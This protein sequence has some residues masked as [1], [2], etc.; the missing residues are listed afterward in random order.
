MKAIILIILTVIIIG[1]IIFRFFQKKAELPGQVSVFD[2]SAIN[3]KIILVK[4]ISSLD[5]QQ[6]IEDFS[7]AYNYPPTIT[8]IKIQ[9]TS[10][11][12][13][14]TFPNNIDFETF[15]FFLNYLQYP[16]DITHTATITGWGTFKEQSILGEKTM[17]YIPS[18]DKEFDNVYAVTTIK[19]NYKISFTNLKPVAIN[20]ATAYVSPP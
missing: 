18:T 2:K 6:I 19:D 16:L 1:L 7:K 10:A 11:T 8:G 13:I 12:D 14:L 17:F 5:L 3:D 20:D 9:S 4:N 15:C